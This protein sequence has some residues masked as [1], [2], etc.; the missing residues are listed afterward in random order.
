[1]MLF[2]D[3]GEKGFTLIEILL[4][5]VIIGVMLA[6]IVPRAWRANTDTK[7]GLV[8]QNCTELAAFAHQWKEA[9]VQAQEETSTAST[10]DYFN[11]LSYDGTNG[12]WVAKDYAS[13]WN[14]NGLSG[15]ANRNVANRVPAAPETDIE[16]MVPPEKMPRNPFNGVSVFNLQNLPSGAGVNHVVP[17]AIA[18]HRNYNPGGAYYFALLFQGTDCT[19]TVM[20][21]SATF[22]AGQ[23]AEPGAGE[24]GLRN[25]I[26]MARCFN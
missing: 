6:V 26:F 19:S 10:Y 24:E 2:T 11:S 4:V 14:K 7:Y 9:M 12:Q 16:S 21:N 8:R 5:V 17:G 13:N 20:S 22:H 15:N 1:M 25:G 3:K 18:A 23:H